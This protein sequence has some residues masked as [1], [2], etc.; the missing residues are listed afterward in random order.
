MGDGRLIATFVPTTDVAH[1]S[2]ESIQLLRI[3]AENWPA[4]QCL[5]ET[6]IRQDPVLQTLPLPAIVPFHRKP[7]SVCGT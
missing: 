1:N 2:R 6:K 4:G 5:F 7:L 3:T